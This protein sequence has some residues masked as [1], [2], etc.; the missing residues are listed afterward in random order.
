MTK[1]YESDLKRLHT[2]YKILAVCYEDLR[3]SSCGVG[4]SEEANPTKVL[5]NKQLYNAG[6]HLRLGAAS[7]KKA[8]D[9]M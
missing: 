6:E 7:L 5:A 2:I 4:E 8:L 1:S 9:N 3:V